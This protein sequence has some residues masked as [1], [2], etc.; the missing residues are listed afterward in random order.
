MYKMNDHLWDLSACNV[1][2]ENISM[3]LGVNI[4]IAF[5]TRRV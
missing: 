2:A 5:G 4:T 1:Q 3:I